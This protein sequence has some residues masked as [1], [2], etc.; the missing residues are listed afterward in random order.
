MVADMVKLNQKKSNGTR[1][2]DLF[3]IDFICLEASLILAFFMRYGVRT[4]IYEVY[5]F[6]YLTIV[7]T[8]VYISLCFVM[9]PHADILTRGFLQELKA[10]FFFETSILLLIILGFYMAKVS[11]DHSRIVL[12]SFYGINMAVSCG[13]HLLWKVWMHK[14]LGK[15]Q[16]YSA[17][18]LVTKQKYMDQCLRRLE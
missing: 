5:N 13:M 10:V 16:Y 4:H 3:V 7:A 11:S 9:K 14:Q 18:V 12:F 15:E 1:Q 17:M 2:T 6:G 8:L